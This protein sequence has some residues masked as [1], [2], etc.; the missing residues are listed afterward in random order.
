MITQFSLCLRKV[1]QPLLSFADKPA[2]CRCWPMRSPVQAT[3]DE[4][5]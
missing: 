4:P 3:K 1:E 2:P 5:A